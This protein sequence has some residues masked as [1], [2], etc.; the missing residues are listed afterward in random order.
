MPPVPVPPI[1]TPV[2]C[3]AVRAPIISWS[4][5]SRAIIIAWII[6]GP[7]VNRARNSDGNMDSCLRFAD[8]EKSPEKNYDENKEKLSHN[9]IR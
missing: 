4:V 1:G 9:W 6:P 8:R 3:I 2:V 7:I 5:I